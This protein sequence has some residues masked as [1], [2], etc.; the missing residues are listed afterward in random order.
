M[1][2]LLMVMENRKDKF[3]RRWLAYANHKMFRHADALHEIGFICWT[4]NGRSFSIGDEV[5]LFMSDERRIRF[6]TRVTADHFVR[7]DGEY[8]IDG[9]SRD[10]LTYKLELAE[11]SDYDGLREE[12]LLLHGFKG[13]KSIQQPIYNNP[14]LF[15]YIADCFSNEDVPECDEIPDPAAVFEGAKKTIQVNSY[16]RNHEARRRCLAAHGYC[17]TVCGMDFEK[18]YGP[19]GHRFIHVHHLV[20][21]STIGKEYKLDPEKDLIPVCPNCHA[22][23]HRDS[24]RTLTVEELKALVELARRSN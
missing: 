6:K 15:E 24:A 5:Y 1:R 13:G 2:K 4:M 14:E 23:L 7:A 12:Y 11:E 8:R 18:T 19:L 21:I 3:P 20:P 22:M 10:N 17:C 9:G 16:E